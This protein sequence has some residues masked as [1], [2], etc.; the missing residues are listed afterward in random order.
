MSKLTAETHCTQA[1]TLFPFTPA[2]FTISVEQSARLIEMGMSLIG[3]LDVDSR[4][5]QALT[6]Q[7]RTEPS[8]WRTRRVRVMWGFFAVGRAGGRRREE[9]IEC[10]ETQWECAVS[11]AEAV[12]EEVVEGEGAWP[13]V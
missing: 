4:R 10:R 9:R 13:E 1:L 12:E 7:G 6:R 3:T 8:S 5:A 11:E 2:D